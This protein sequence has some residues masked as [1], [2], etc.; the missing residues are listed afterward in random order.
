M[1]RRALLLTGGLLVRVQPEEPARKTRKINNL[2]TL[3]VSRRCKLLI[4]SDLRHRAALDDVR[5]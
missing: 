5:N 3:G 2:D 1:I 4:L